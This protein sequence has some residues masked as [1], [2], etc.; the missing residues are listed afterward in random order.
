MAGQQFQY[1][2]SG[3]TFFYFLTSF[4]GLIVI[5]ATYY[6]WPRDQNAGESRRRTAL[7]RSGG[8]SAPGRAVLPAG[9]A[10]SPGDAA[11]AAG[12]E[13]R[14]RRGRS[15]AA[16]SGAAGPA[17]LLRGPREFGWAPLR[18]VLGAPR[19]P[20]LCLP[21]LCFCWVFSSGGS[22][23][24]WDGGREKS[25]PRRKRSVRAQ[26]RILRSRHP[27][28]PLFPESPLQLSVQMFGGTPELGGMFGTSK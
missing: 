7:A 22:G 17:A 21:S 5:P 3:N 24:G 20:P 1:D 9:A 18:I 10:P 15:S 14:R 12:P 23:M 27:S 2:D 25:W 16:I 26:L 19:P 28:F 11:R 6:L 13:G 4:V 8:R